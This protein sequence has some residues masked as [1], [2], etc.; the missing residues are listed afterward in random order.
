MVPHAK[1][2]YEACLAEG[3]PEALDHN[4]PDATGIGPA[5]LNHR[6]GVRMSTALTYLSEARHRLNLTIRPNVTARRVLF[7]GRRAVGVEAESGGDRFIVEGDQIVLSA[8]GIAS[9]QLLMLS[10][11][12]PAEQLE[13]LGIDLVH[14]LPGV[15]Q[16]LRDHPLAT[17]LFR[18]TGEMPTDLEAM[19]S[20]LLRYTVAGSKTR[21]D[22]ANYRYS[23]GSCVSAG[24]RPNRQK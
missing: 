8:G 15:G 9:P 2:F 6:N 20:V 7:E 22:N 13:S 17:L 21:D 23:I 19:V 18:E 12:G 5:P 16:N 4:H 3:F 1:A 14:N 10:G 24:R 11:V